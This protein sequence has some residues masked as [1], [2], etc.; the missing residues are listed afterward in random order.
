[1]DIFNLNLPPENNDK[2][3]PKRLDKWFDFM[4]K[5][6]GK[7]EESNEKTMLNDLLMDNDIDIIE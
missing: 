3:D 1:M 6:F 5:Q 2:K 7:I 4:N